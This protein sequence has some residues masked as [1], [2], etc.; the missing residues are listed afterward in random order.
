MDKKYELIIVGGGPAGIAAGIYGTRRK[1]K[2]LIITQSFGGQMVRK[3]VAIENYPG[4]KSISGADLVSQMVEQLK[5]NKAEILNDKVSR[6]TKE[7]DEFIIKTN[8]GEKFSA[9]AVIVSSGADP[10]PLEVPGEKEYIGRGISYCTTCDAPLFANKDVA[11]VGGG[12]SGFEA[13]LSMQKYAN[14]IY[15][16]EASDK[17]KAE[18][19]NQ[20]M[21]AKEKKIQV[22]ASAAV[23]KIEGDKFVKSLTYQDLKT[24]E[25]KTLLVE[26]IFIEIGN[27]PATGFLNSLVDFNE[28]D[29]II[30]DPKTCQTK[31]PGLYAAG[32]VTDVKYKQIVVACGEGTKA[33]LSVAEYLRNKN[34]AD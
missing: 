22:I 1:I 20:I 28:K 33:L 17:P 30:V 6:I 12:N 25:I 23:Q 18:E 15:I 10:R 21:A 19:I 16:L 5:E 8:G 3:S 32:D 26:G 14:K 13:A 7:K 27:I 11:V 24:K 4:F 9:A 34:N 2:L 31:T 29:E